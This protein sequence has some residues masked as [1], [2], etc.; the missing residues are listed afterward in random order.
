MIDLFTYDERHLRSIKVE[1]GQLISHIRY[2]TEEPKISSRSVSSLIVC[3]GYWVE[4]PV[5]G[6][7]EGVGSQKSV[8]VYECTSFNNGGGGGSSIPVNP[9]S[10]PPT[11]GGSPTN[12]PPP[13]GNP[14]EDDESNNFCRD[15]QCIPFPEEDD[16]LPGGKYWESEDYLRKLMATLQEYRLQANPGVKDYRTLSSTQKF[17]HILSHINHNR[18]LR[19][20]FRIN[21]IM[22]NVSRIAPAGK[23]SPPGGY[24][25]SGEAAVL[26]N[27]KRYIIGYRFGNRIGYDHINMNELPTL[28]NDIVGKDQFNVMYKDLNVP[29]RTALELFFP[30]ELYQWFLDNY[31]Y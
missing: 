4:F 24:Y 31:Y 1:N 16:K 14:G 12:P 3:S 9:P 6:I 10:G 2:Q 17:L 13:T 25:E 11:G 18:H 28:N 15:N 29:G 30:I 27:G 22:S 21:E 8:Y 23:Y 5:Y 20:S 7:R 26:I 19:N